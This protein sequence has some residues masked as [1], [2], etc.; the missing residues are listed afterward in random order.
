MRCVYKSPNATEQNDKVLFSLLELANKSMTINDKFC[1]IGYLNYPCIKWNGISAH[2]R[3]FEF[4]ETI[5]DA[6][7]YQMV[8]KSAKSR[9][10]QTASIND[11]VLVNDEIFITEIEHCCPLGKCDHQVLRCS[12]HLDCLFDLSTSTKTVF[13]FSKADFDGLRDHSPKYNDWTLLID[14]DINEGRNLI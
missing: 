3:D 14:L 6:Y 11:L 8:T 7:L 2:V 12:M 13:D 5:C 1:I 10:G 4:V 9:L